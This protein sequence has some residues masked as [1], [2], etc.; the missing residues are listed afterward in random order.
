M[1][2]A[3]LV[4]AV[5]EPS[6]GPL[7]GVEMAG[8]AI[9]LQAVAF[10]ER[11]RAVDKATGRRIGIGRRAD[12]RPI[13]GHA[14]CDPDLVA[15]VV[16]LPPIGHAPPGLGQWT[17][18]GVFGSE[19]ACGQ[20]VALR[21]G[22][23]VALG[24]G[25]APDADRPGI[26]YPGNVPRGVVVKAGG[27][28]GKIPQV[29]GEVG[30]GIVSPQVVHVPAA[31]LGSPAGQIADVLPGDIVEG[32]DVHGPQ[33][34]GREAHRD[35]RCVPFVGSDVVAVQRGHRALRVREKDNDLVSVPIKAVA[36]VPRILDGG[37][38]PTLRRMEG[39]AVG[40]GVIALG[41]A[42]GAVPAHRPE[43]TILDRP[44]HRAVHRRHRAGGARFPTE[45]LANRLHDAGGVRV[46][47]S[48]DVHRG[49]HLVA[50]RQA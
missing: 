36:A 13:L 2:Q 7:L 37:R 28:V 27:V 33:A 10:A 32:S 40:L 12:E 26:A 1:H 44:G 14:I 43:P 18:V 47:V 30:I 21:V 20:V 11:G 39:P 8:P 9:P 15:A 17:Q 16:D 50:R 25:A 41:R 4:G 29:D 6:A 3:F 38:N 35:G 34:I 31:A 5:G 19:G 42:I 23:D 45:E 24:I 22:D 46:A 49:Q 48:R